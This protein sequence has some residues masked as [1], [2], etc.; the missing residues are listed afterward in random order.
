MRREM[1]DI[2]LSSAGSRSKGRTTEAAKG[3]AAGARA[4]F[5]LFSQCPRSPDCC[6]FAQSNETLT[7]FQ[8]F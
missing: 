7:P 5:Q 4:A 8:H 2:P 3:V 1:R 6:P